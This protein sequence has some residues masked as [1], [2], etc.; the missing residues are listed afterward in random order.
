MV[1]LSCKWVSVPVIR[2]GKCSA[3]DWHPV[4]SLYWVRGPDE[5]T[6]YSYQLVS[7]F[8]VAQAKKLPVRLAVSFDILKCSAGRMPQISPLSPSN[9]PQHM[10][11]WARYVAFVS[12]SLCECTHNNDFD[13]I[14]LYCHT[15]TFWFHFWWLW[16]AHCKL[17]YVSLRAVQSFEAV[18][19]IKT[20]ERQSKLRSLC[21]DYVGK[22]I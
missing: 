18:A 1:Q 5:F 17:Y 14:G 9:F 12:C 10:C 2:L 6:F 3:S 11:K 4:T 8:S 21:L 7:S 20:Q 19:P 13:V 16:D 15:G 22:A